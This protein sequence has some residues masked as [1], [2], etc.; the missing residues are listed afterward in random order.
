MKKVYIL[1]GLLITSTYLFSQSLFESALSSTSKG[2]EKSFTLNGFVRSDVFA[3]ETDFRSIYAESALK[4]ETKNSKYGNAFAEL[5]LQKNILNDKKPVNVDLREAYINLYFGNVDFR[6]GQQI[7]VWG[8]ADGFNPTNNLTPT[9]FTVF[10]PDEDD[11]RLSNFVVKGN[12]NFKNFRLEA[13]WIPFYKASILPFDTY[14]L[15]D[16]VYWA[17][18]NY[19]ETK[20]TESSYALKFSIEKAA[21]DG[22]LSYFN[23][24]NK[25]PGLQTKTNAEGEYYVLLTTHR[26]QVVGADFSTILDRYGL[27]G[28]FAF[29]IACEDEDI[30]QSV[31]KQQFEY[32]IGIDREWGNFSLIAQ[33]IGKYVFDFK[34][35]V[36]TD[37]SYQSQLLYELQLWNRMIFNQQN[38]WNHSVSLRPSISMFHQT[39]DFEILGLYHFSTEEIYVKPKLSCHLSDNISFSTGVQIF[40][41]PAETMF[42]VL[43]KSKNAGFIECKISF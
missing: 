40:S 35:L 27:R 25:L 33:Y 28:E 26:T 16:G 42:N 19:P 37:N 21:F 14:T 15:P 13:D 43:G 10:S 20:W 4:L 1:F 41:G 9:D 2:N 31:P 18:A 24:N 38:K 23:G 3:N 8:R 36:I 6:I 12:Y 11:K 34:E 17:E 7:I 29:T 39:L 5:R 30:Y 22:S 32:T